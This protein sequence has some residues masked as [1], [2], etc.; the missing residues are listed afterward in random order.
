MV[1]KYC[2]VMHAAGWSFE[3]ARAYYENHGQP[4]HLDADGDGIPCERCTE[5]AEDQD[6]HRPRRRTATPPTRTSAYRHRLPTLTAPTLA[7]GSRLTT[8]T[9][10]RTAWT[11]MATGMGATRTASEISAIVLPELSAPGRTGLDQSG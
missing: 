3:K 8:A 10:T 1:G 6:Q 2:A 4:A 11:P 9:A 5:N 7:T